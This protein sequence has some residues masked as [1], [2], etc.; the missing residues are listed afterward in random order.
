MLRLNT[1]DGLATV[2]KNLTE[3][4]PDGDPRSYIP[5]SPPVPLGHFQTQI[6]N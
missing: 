5:P 6:V 4:D 2:L 3:D 1:E